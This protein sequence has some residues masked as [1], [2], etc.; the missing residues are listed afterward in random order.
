MFLFSAAEE[1]ISRD[2]GMC[3]RSRSF[4]ALICAGL[5]LVAA[6][7]FHLFHVSAEMHNADLWLVEGV[8]LLG[9]TDI[10]YSAQ[11]GP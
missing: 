8:R 11:H 10:D 7:C 2:V 4:M 5:A 1:M 3:L 9:T 6:C